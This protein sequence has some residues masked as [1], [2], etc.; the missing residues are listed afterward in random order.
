MREHACRLFVRLDPDR[1]GRERERA[2]TA[3]APCAQTRALLVERE[4]LL[5]VDA[6]R[7]ETFDFGK[8]ESRGKED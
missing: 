6:V 3:N 5:L 1:F 2:E 4:L 8:R 7:K